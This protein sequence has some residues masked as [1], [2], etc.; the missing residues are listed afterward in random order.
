MIR[1]NWKWSDRMESICSAFIESFSAL[2]RGIPEEVAHVTEVI[3]NLS[4]DPLSLPAFIYLIS[5]T[6]DDYIRLCSIINIRQCLKYNWEI[7]QNKEAYIDQFFALMVKETDNL[8]RTNL[9]N[10]IYPLITE[11]SLPHAIQFAR[12][13][14]D[15]MSIPHIHSS[16][17][18]LDNLLGLMKH[19]PELLAFT[20]KLTFAGLTISDPE[21]IL[22]ALS[23][24]FNYYIINKVEIDDNINQLWVMSC[25]FV[26]PFMNNIHNFHHLCR[27]LS[28]VVEL[29]SFADVES[30]MPILLSIFEKDG[31]E[32]DM[33]QAIIMIIDSCCFINI[34]YFMEEEKYKALFLRYCQISDQLYIPDQL[35]DL[36]G[37]DVFSTIVSVFSAEEE[38]LNFVWELQSQ[39]V[40]QDERLAV[41]L[42]FYKYSFKVSPDFFFDNLDEVAT[43]ISSSLSNESLLIRDIA[44]EAVSEFASEFQGYIGD[45]IDLF[46]EPILLSIESQPSQEMLSVLSVLFERSRNTDNIYDRALPLLVGLIEIVSIETNMALLPAIAQLLKYSSFKV[47]QNLEEV[48]SIMQLI[49]TSDSESEYSALRAGAVQ[50]I[51]SLIHKCPHQFDGIAQEVAEFLINCLENENDPFLIAESLNTFGYM[52]MTH[53][54]QI[55][56]V[57]EYSLQILPIL[58]S[59]DL[60]DDL[61]AITTELA[62]QT[63]VTVEDDIDEKEADRMLIDANAMEFPGGAL[64]V[65]SSII[66]TYP[67]FFNDNLQNMVDMISKMSDSVVGHSVQKSMRAIVI[68][69][70]GMMS[71]ETFDTVQID[72]I[73]SIIQ[74]VIEQDKDITSV[75]DA[76]ES[77]A[78]MICCI[79]VSRIPNYIDTIID[80]ADSALEINLPCINDDKFP[81]ELHHSLKLLFRELLCAYKNEIPERI[82]K[83]IENRI[84]P[85]TNSNKS[86]DSLFAISIMAKYIEYSGSNI[87][88]NILQNLINRCIDIQMKQETDMGF[89]TIKT[90]SEC[91]PSLMTP[92]FEPIIQLFRSKLCS[93][94]KSSENYVKMIDNCVSA[95]G[96]FAMNVCPNDFPVSEF[97][98]K[99][100]EN[101]PAALDIGEN[102]TMIQ[103]FFWLLDRVGCT[104]AQLVCSVLV[105]LFSSSEYEM[106]EMGITQETLTKLRDMM[107]VLLSKIP[108]SMQFCQTVLKNNPSKLSSLQGWIQ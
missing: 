75:G 62:S 50:C 101:M 95:I 37:I 46:E 25:S 69:F 11:N 30:I 54:S 49:I 87:T 73:Y 1:A 8:C 6:D 18:L 96:A 32:L 14:L 104:D 89:F 91:I 12:M 41:I 17:C 82:Q 43:I 85:M 40:E 10:T 4:K 99:C 94:R 19:S 103:F 70:E 45:Y 106:K 53:K 44:K 52:L 15:S 72:R 28:D 51:G 24:A 48:F 93:R 88:E 3:L 77:L 78:A 7:N 35:M 27:I 57:I 63:E 105:K 21:V 55:A 38:F 76:F 58:V 92:F 74:R 90:A 47:S 34:G 67:E 81:I 26:E 13:S 107:I 79:G 9:V 22:S 80:L 98:V 20:I 42:L 66:T 33:A 61:I 68:I 39:F 84:I 56:P 83:I 64:M 97:A 71:F 108:N 36:V 5:E 31:L 60:N 23:F 102:L 65:Y 16:L 2:R 100:F 59:K 86:S 29:S